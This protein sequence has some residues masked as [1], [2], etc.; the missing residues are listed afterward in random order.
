MLRR[1]ANNNNDASIFAFTFPKPGTYVFNDS[2]NA[3]K[4]MVIQVMGPGEEC[5]DSDRFVQT[6]TADSMAE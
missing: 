3:Q 1:K 2:A 6:I 5:A 4:I